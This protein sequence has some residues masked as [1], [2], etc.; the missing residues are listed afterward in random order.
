[1]EFGNVA[2]VYRD[3]F[4]FQIASRAR[5]CDVA[6]LVAATSRLARLFDQGV[7][8]Y[9]YLLS[10]REYLSIGLQM[11]V[12][13]VGLDA[14]DWSEIHQCYDEMYQVAT[15]NGIDCHPFEVAASSDSE[16]EPDAVS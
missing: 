13:L 6:V 16:A 3:L 7:A 10:L 1:M 5:T 9:E 4:K 8:S 12:W 11:P 15:A 14:S 2:S